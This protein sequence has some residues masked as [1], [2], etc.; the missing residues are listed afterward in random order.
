[1]IKIQL[2]GYSAIPRVQIVN[3]KKHRCKKKDQHFAQDYLEKQ[4]QRTDDGHHMFE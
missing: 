4:T 3:N 1:M 2:P